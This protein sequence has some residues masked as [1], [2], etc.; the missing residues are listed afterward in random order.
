MTIRVMNLLYYAGRML[1]EDTEN[2]APVVRQGV[3]SKLAREIWAKDHG[4]NLT[5]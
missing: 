4:V 2:V 5:M 3:D 1:T